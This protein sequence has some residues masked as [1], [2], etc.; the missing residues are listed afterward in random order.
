MS[1]SIEGGE[2]TVR[3]ISEEVDLASR[4]LMNFGGRAGFLLRGL[5]ERRNGVGRILMQ[6]KNLC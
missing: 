6:K 1:F 2:K 5:R 4:D 3:F